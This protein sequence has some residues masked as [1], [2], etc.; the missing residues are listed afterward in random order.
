VTTDVR[1]D[2]GDAALVADCLAGDRSAWDAL[3]ERHG[4][5]VWAVARRAGLDDEDAADVFQNTWIIA[6]EE[7]SRIREPALFGRWLGR[8]ARHQCMRVRRGYG[9][10]RKALPNVAR[11]DVDETVPDEELVRLEDRS[12]VHAALDRV[13]ERCAGL[14]RL[15]Y[16]DSASPA[17][18]EIADRLDMRIGSIG[19]TRAR[20]LQRL[21]GLL[22]GGHHD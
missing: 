4:P 22:E 11:Q 3:L 6:L 8:V 9:I 17:Y 19:P 16:M 2:G 7:L 14:L 15:L 21:R 18:A 20:C 12:R 10:A 13:G 5:L 1:R